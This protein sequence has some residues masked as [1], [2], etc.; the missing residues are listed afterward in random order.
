LGEKRTENIEKSRGSR[1]GWSC[2]GKE[3]VESG[4]GVVTI[5]E[6]ATVIKKG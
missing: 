1:N 5:Y 2:T 4:R 6:K 3:Q